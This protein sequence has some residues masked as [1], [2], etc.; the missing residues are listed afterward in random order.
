MINIINLSILRKE[1]QKTQKQVSEETGI[2]LRTLQRY[3][4]GE[5]IGDPEYLC[6]LMR[7]FNLNANDLLI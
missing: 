7:Y 2:P 3:E 6:I 1:F 4:K 5:N